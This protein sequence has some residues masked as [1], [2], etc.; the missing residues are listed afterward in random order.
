MP[1]VTPVC[2]DSSCAQWFDIPEGAGNSVTVCDNARSCD[3][4]FVIDMTTAGLM[5]YEK[6]SASSSAKERQHSIDIDGFIRRNTQYPASKKNILAQAVGKKTRTIVDA[7]GGW[8]GDSLALCAQGYIVTLLERDWLLAGFLRE[9]MRRLDDSDW[10][11]RHD[12]SV[13]QVYAVDAVDYFLSTN[14]QVD[15]VYLDP[16]FPPKRK[17]SALAKK[18]MQVLHRWLPPQADSESLFE[19]AWQTQV[20]RVAVKRPDYGAALGQPLGVTPSEQFDSKLLR[21]DVYLRAV[22]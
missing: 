10:A 3:A 22:E 5:L 19:A 11:K 12:V 13:P 20:R 17:S 14:C 18:D 21:Y 9:A 2:I 6:D 1:M 16:M 15:C 8:G 4:N 7:T